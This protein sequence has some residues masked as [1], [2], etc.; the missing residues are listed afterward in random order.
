MGSPIS[1]LGGW[2]SAIQLGGNYTTPNATLS[3]EVVAGLHAD[4]SVH[5]GLTH[6]AAAEAIVGVA[7]FSSE[8]VGIVNFGIP[9]TWERA[10]YVKKLVT[11][12]IG[13][14]VARGIAKGWWF[15]QVWA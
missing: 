13:I 5:V 11:L 8:D 1:E 7:G 6:V 14:S 10:L 12:T 9:E 2:V 4:V 3:L 15:I